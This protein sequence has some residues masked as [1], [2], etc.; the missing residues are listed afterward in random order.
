QE[1]ADDL[2]QRTQIPDGDLPRVCL[3]DSGVNRG[4]PLLAP[5]MDSAD[6]HTVEPAWGVDD[7]ANHG[8]GLAGLIG[9][10]DLTD[11]LAS[12]A[13]IE[14]P[15]RLE[16]V[17]LVAQDGANDGDARH[18]AYL[19]KEGVAR[20]EIAAPDRLR[21]FSS[22]VTASDYRDRGRPSSWSSAVDSL[23]ADTDGA[24]HYPR[25]FVLSAGNI[26]DQNAWAAYPDSLSANLVHDPG[27][28]WKAI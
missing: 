6:L 7:T 16:S 12:D 2:L 11:A 13:A 22:A 26:R 21:V 28:A 17:K 5:L 18:H 15:H 9:Y 27:Q 1:W 19:F 3:L 8:T 14:I 10:G 4:H 20:P 24:G 23:A 25:L